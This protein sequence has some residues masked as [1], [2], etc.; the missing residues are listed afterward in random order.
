MGRTAHM[1]LTSATENCKD[2]Y[3]NTVEAGREKGLY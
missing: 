3:F 1:A 2:K